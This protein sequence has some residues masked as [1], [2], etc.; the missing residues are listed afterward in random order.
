M[1]F[2]KT[3]CNLD[4]LDFLLAA[5]WAF[6]VLLVMASVGDA[7]YRTGDNNILIFSIVSVI[8][9]NIIFFLMIIFQIWGHLWKFLDDGDKVKN[10]LYDSMYKNNIC[11]VKLTILTSTIPII[12]ILCIKFYEISLI[13]FVLYLLAHVARMIFRLV[14]RF[15][16]HEK[17]VNAHKGEGK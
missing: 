15:N 10:I 14:K 1:K 4:S 3:K 7:A 17:N 6:T 11:P 12:V 9:T 8:F 13:L 2:L 5:S 16:L